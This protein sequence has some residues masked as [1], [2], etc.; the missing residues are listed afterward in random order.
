MFIMILDKYSDERLKLKLFERVLEFESFGVEF[1]IDNCLE[2]I[3]KMIF[4]LEWKLM[5][6]FEE[7]KIKLFDFLCIYYV[8]LR[9][10]EVNVIFRRLK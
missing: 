5:K 8:G 9:F 4:I 1:V 3:N 7:I 2:I 6:Y 10:F